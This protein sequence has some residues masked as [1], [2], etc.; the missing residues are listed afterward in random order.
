MSRPHAIHHINF[1]VNDLDAAVSRYRRAF[2]FEP[3]M[4][5]ELPDR[6]VRT[7]RFPLG[8]TW[9]VLVQPT[10]EDSL[11]GR[12]LRERGEGVF[13]VSLAVAELDAAMAALAGAGASALDA[14]PRRGLQGWRVQDLEP[15]DFFGVRLQLTEAARSSPRRHTCPESRR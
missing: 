1:V 7:A 8:E 13:L 15:E 9:L 10:R 3:P 14:E 6:G 5:E 2:G 4:C 11:P 12:H